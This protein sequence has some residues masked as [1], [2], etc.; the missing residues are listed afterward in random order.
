MMANTV[1]GAQKTLTVAWFTGCALL[2][3]ESLAT[4][5]KFGPTLWKWWLPAAAPTATLIVGVLVQHFRDGGTPV[6]LNDRFLFRLALF[7]IAA[8]FAV[9]FVVP[10]LAVLWE[11]KDPRQFVDDSQLFTTP[12]HALITA[13]LGAFFVEKNTK[14]TK[15]PGPEATPPPPPRSPSAAPRA[16]GASPSRA[17]R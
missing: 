8:C 16:G 4:M 7:L 1:A 12:L 11:V 17:R 3:V 2:F 6:P 13:A 15:T 5:Q 10:V 9:M 14:G